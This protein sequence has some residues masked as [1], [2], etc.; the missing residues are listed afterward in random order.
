MEKG[1]IKKGFTLI[2]LLLVIAI[3]GI[4]SSIVFVSNRNSIVSSQKSSVIA[5]ASS[6]FPE[7]SM[8]KEDAGKATSSAPVS[9]NF[10]CCK[11]SEDCGN[12][13]DKNANGHSAKW[14]DLGNTGWNYAGAPT[15][16]IAVFSYKFTVKLTSDPTQVITCD[17]A[18]NEC[19][20]N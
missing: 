20:S 13:V 7:L 6:V 14:P 12:E 11:D 2:E 16:T 15:G 17:F 8:C 18:T 1:K 3:M 10:I 19:I 9:G 5:S 4:L